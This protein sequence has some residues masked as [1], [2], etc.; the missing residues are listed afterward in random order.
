[1]AGKPWSE[2]AKRRW[3]DKQRK[4]GEANHEG[5]H[6]V[7]A[8]GADSARGTGNPGGDSAGAGGV[9]VRKSLEGQYAGPRHAHKPVP[10]KETGDDKPVIDFGVIKDSLPETLIE[11]N[12]LLSDVASAVTSNKKFRRRYFLKPL[13]PEKAKAEAEFLGRLLELVLPSFIK[14]H[15]ML[16]GLFVVAVRPA[17]RLRSEEKPKEGKDETQAE[18]EKVGAQ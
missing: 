13:T 5:A 6:H 17:M 2:E 18:K 11:Y 16:A 1:M 14:D 4:R 10:K 15:P 7:G 9:G 8:G 12:E 3:A